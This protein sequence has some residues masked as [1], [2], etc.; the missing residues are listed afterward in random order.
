MSLSDKRQTEVCNEIRKFLQSIAIE[1][2]RA[3]DEI[4]SPDT[5]LDTLCDIE[6]DLHRATKFTNILAMDREEL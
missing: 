6:S 4:G 1:A 5:L 2:V 3:Q